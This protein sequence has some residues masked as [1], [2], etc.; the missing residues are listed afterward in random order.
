MQLKKQD[1]SPE[2]RAALGRLAKTGDAKTLMEL[3]KQQGGAESAAREA[4]NG[5]PGALVDLVNRLMQSDQG[6]EVIRRLSD[7][8]R[9]QGLK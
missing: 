1:I 5:N 8:A 9:E 4:K 7:Q 6:A 2:Q 3:L